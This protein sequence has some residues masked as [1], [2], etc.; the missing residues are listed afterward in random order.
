M[1]NPEMV[2]QTVEL[3]WEAIDNAGVRINIIVNNRAGG[4][5]PLVGQLI[6]ER[7][8]EMGETG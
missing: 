5:A 8:L 4:N 7:F 1:L 6:A 2:E 3:M